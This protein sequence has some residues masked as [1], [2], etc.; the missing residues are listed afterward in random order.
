MGNVA[1]E[2]GAASLT[3]ENPMDDIGVVDTRWVKR[4]VLRSLEVLFHEHKWE[5]LADIALRFTDISK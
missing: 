2:K 5:R 1:M 3:F 4:L